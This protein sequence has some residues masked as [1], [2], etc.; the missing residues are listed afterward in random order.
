MRPAFL[1]D[2]DEEEEEE[3]EDDSVLL[4]PM[5]GGG[6]DA[7]TSVQPHQSSSVSATSAAPA[8]NCSTARRSPAT[9]SSIF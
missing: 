9:W 5:V 6:K 3:D 8:P 7:V 4:S 1:T 2:Q